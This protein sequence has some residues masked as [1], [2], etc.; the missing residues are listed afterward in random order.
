MTATGVV[1]IALL[2]PTPQGQTHVDLI[3][4]LA[5]YEHC[6]DLSTECTETY[7]LVEAN[8]WGICRIYAQIDLL[9]PGHIPSQSE[10]FEK[11][12]PTNAL[13][14]CAGGDIHSPNHGLM[15]EFGHVLAAKSNQANQ[16]LSLESA[17]DATIRLNCQARLDCFPRETD[18]FLI[19]GAEG[20]GD[21]LQA[22]QA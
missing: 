2:D 16:L 15:S 13:R 4:E 17:K 19:A 5:S 3:V 14:P 12:C 18:F 20:R 8:S 22:S 9:E 1:S 7:R 6:T 10:C 11:K 21:F